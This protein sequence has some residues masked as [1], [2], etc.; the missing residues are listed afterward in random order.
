MIEQGDCIYCKEGTVWSF[1]DEWELEPHT[2][3]TIGVL[4]T[5]TKQKLVVAQSWND[6]QW[7]R[8]FVIPKGA[9]KEM[10]YLRCEK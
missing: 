7:G 9:I 4:V 6:D 1:K 3:Y 5:D 8:L 2:C 10:E